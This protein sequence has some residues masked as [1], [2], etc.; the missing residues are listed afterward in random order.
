VT[1][2]GSFNLVSVVRA[3][4]CVCIWYCFS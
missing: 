1:Y 4:I 3:C 2:T